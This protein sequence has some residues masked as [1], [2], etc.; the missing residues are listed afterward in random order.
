M[1]PRTEG[2]RYKTQGGIR[3]MAAIALPMIVSQGC[4][5]VMTFTD[6]LFLS[7]LGPDNMNAA[8]GGWL[9]VFLIMT[10]FLGLTSYVTALVAQCLG[11]R[12]KERCAVVFVQAVIV[13]LAAY[14]LILSFR[15][16]VHGLFGR[17]G[18][19]P[20]Q[21]VFQKAYFDILIYGVIVTLLRNALSGY[22]SGIGRARVV[23]RA[24][25]T[26]MTVNIA[27]NYILIFGKFGM[28]ALGIRGAA[29]GT[30]CGGICALG[31]LLR[32]YFGKANRDEF[33]ISQA[34]RFD[35]EMML[36]YL[37]YGSPVGLEMFL[38]LSAFNLVVMIFHSV[39][40]V[41]A[42]AIT[43]M[44]NW[45]MVSFLP[46]LGVDVAVTSL[47]GRYM[48]AG[49]PDIASRVTA[50]GLKVGLVYS[51]VVLFF[52]AGFPGMLV[53]IF[54]PAGDGTIFQAARPVAVTMVRL[55]SLYVMFLVPYVVF[56]GAMRGA[57]DTMWAMGLSVTTNWLPVPVLFVM[58]HMLG[59][60]PRSAW[61]AFVLLFLLCVVFVA[62]RFKSGQWK[63]IRV[64]ASVKP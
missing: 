18:L 13:L 39:S 1:G 33:R 54:H 38:I 62:W 3:E 21:L 36:T 30:I 58:L 40:A 17:I 11:A 24:S 55:A 61:L 64:I 41:S 6:R 60:G 52:F 22:F 43:I 25:L 44:L 47:V 19:V 14:P 48:G 56:M 10:F 26:A 51:V 37:R 12:Q 63:N 5:T 15:P 2:Q 27:A 59:S 50:S 31:I 46:L 49:R 9:T 42:T 57:G 7:R 45:D 34:F 29:L 8:L 16:L 20:Q 4:D 23:M 35:R 53:D 32:E 28:P